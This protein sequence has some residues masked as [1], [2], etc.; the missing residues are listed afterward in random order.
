METDV[1]SYEM[2]LAPALAALAAVLLAWRLGLAATEITYVT[3]ADGRRAIRNLPLLFK[4]VLPFAANVRAF[5]KPRYD[6][7]RETVRRKI[8]SAGFDG[9][10]SPQEFL[11]TKILMPL[12]VGPVLIL[13]LGFAFN[14]VP[15]GFGEFLQKRQLIFYLLVVALL[16]IH[17]VSWLNGAVKARHR[18]IERAMPFVLDLLTLSV[19]AGLDFGAALK[20]IVER[21]EVDP[22]GE[23]L[24]RALREMQVGRTRR[25]ALKEMAVRVDHPDMSSWVNALIQADELGVSIGNILRIQADQ[26]RIRRFQRAEKMGNE[27]PVKLLFPLVCFI[28]PAVFLVLLGP[29]L[30]EL[31]QKGF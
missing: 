8:I 7:M 5:N 14:A 15:G 2:I 4:L 17:P 19:E 10:I 29:I 13:I 21:R 24:I 12:A 30:L 18:S 11:A 1:F 26:I 22:L 31:A 16:Y 28:F 3:L 6:G 23:E 25:E 20:R 27:A 9:I